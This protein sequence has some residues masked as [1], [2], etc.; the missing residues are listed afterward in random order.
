MELDD[1]KKSWQTIDEKLQSKQ[2]I[3][4]EELLKIIQTKKTSA[5][6]AQKGLVNYNL[7]ILGITVILFAYILLSKEKYFLVLGDLFI[8]V[9]V[10]LI[11]IVIPW[12]IYT[13]R[14]LYKTDIYNMPLTTV[15]KR[16]NKYN[17]WMT[18]ERVVGAMIIFGF[19]LSSIIVL[20][21]WTING[22]FPYFVYGIWTIAFIIYFLI[23][24]KITF[25][26]LKNIR[27]N[28]DE[29]KEVNFEN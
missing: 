15:V 1:L 7:I 21:P 9:L 4:D 14:Y 8:G 28:L 10:L 12:N 11:A 27:K 16:I 18:V 19:A 13:L 3:K 20:Q 23:I 17:Y 26:R 24:N 2:F 25:R 22:W 6:K 5:H 29:L